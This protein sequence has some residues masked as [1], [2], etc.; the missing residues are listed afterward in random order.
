MT[1][2]KKIRSLLLFLV[3]LLGV[4]GL[5]FGQYTQIAGQVIDPNGN[6]YA[7][8]TYRVDFIPGPSCN[9]PYVFVNTQGTG[10]FQTSFGGQLDSSGNLPLSPNAIRVADVNQIQSCLGSQW[11]FAICSQ[12]TATIG[13]TCFST[14]LSPTGSNFSV[15]ALLQAAAASLPSAVTTGGAA[16]QV[17]TGQSTIVPVTTPIQFGTCSLPLGILATGTASTSTVVWSFAT[18]PTKIPGYGAPGSP[19]LS[20]YAFV[21]P[22]VANTINF[23]ICNQDARSNPLASF[24]PFQVKINWKVIF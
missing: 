8:G 2:L 6:T 4:S 14:L 17:A 20:V 23:V 22:T 15:T 3:V 18:D 10:A 12:S 19:I 13:P 7:N 9:A 11:Q 21:S 16:K 5:A 24:A 1:G